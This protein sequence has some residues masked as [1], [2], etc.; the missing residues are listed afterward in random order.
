MTTTKKEKE[1]IMQNKTYQVKKHLIEKGCIDS[2]TAINKY[3]A[4]RLSAIIF[5]L[6][7]RGMKI[8]SKPMTSKDRNNNFCRFVNYVLID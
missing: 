6:R 8:I 1:K 3:G 2:W 4:T 5:N 7:N